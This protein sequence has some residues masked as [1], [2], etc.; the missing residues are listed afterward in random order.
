MTKWKRN[1]L[2]EEAEQPE[3]RGFSF[4]DGFHFG[5]GFFIAWLAGTTVVVALAWAIA[6]L[7][8]IR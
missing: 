1:F 6:A 4:Q 2:G 7:F 5:F 8:N 3:S